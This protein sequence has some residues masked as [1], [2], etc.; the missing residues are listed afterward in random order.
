MAHK[1][2]PTHT[3]TNVQNPRD[4]NWLKASY[5]L[6]DILKILNN[7]QQHLHW[8]EVLNILSLPNHHRWNNLCFGSQR[9][10]YL[11]YLIWSFEMKCSSS[12]HSEQISITFKQAI[13]VLESLDFLMSALLINTRYL[14]DS[15]CELNIST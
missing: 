6:V 2:P 3:H 13:K 14:E 4:C 8:E 9:L 15:T 12:V 5:L 1:H 11:H 7:S 10:W